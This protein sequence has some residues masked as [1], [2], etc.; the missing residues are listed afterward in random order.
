M[1]SIKIAS[2]SSDQP[3]AKSVSDAPAAVLLPVPM[4]VTTRLLLWRFTLIRPIASSK[5]TTPEALFGAA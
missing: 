3:E 2:S 4:I 1:P 5:E